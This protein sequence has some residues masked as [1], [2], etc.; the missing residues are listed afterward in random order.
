MLARRT[1]LSGGLGGKPELFLVCDVDLRRTGGSDKFF[2]AQGNSLRYE[3]K[4][5]LKAWLKCM[6]LHF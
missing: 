4:W 5:V 2:L 3:L 6:E 1:V